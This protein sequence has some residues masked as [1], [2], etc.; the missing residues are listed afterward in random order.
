MAFMD[1]KEPICLRHHVEK[2][3]DGYFACLDGSQ[4]SNLYPMV[5]REIE[6]SLIQY[7]LKHTKN[8]QSMTAE[9]LG[10]SRGT[11]RKKIRDL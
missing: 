11:L 8:N 3:L 4:P 7:V 6:A 9:L 10:I 5:L 1:K 2:A